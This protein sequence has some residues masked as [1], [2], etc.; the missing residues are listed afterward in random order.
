MT[1]SAATALISVCGLVFGLTHR[2]DNFT[3][4]SIL[5]FSAVSYSLM[6]VSYF[7]YARRLRATGWFAPLWFISHFPAAILTLMEMR[8]TGR[9]PVEERQAQKAKMES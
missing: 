6:A 4:A 5:A 2:I 3:G 8:G 7:V 9:R 1:G